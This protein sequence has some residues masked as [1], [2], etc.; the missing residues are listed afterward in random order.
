MSNNLRQMTKSIFSELEFAV[1]QEH[2]DFIVDVERHID[3]D[4]AYR[5]KCCEFLKYAKIIGLNSPFPF[6]IIFIEYKEKVYLGIDSRYAET[7][8]RYGYIVEKDLWL[9]AGAELLCAA[10]KFGRVKADSD[11]IIQY[12]LGIEP[13]EGQDNVVFSDTDIREL[14][15]DI[16]LFNLDINE[17]SLSVQFQQDL[18]RIFLLT[19]RENESVDGNNSLLASLA[20]KANCRKIATNLVDYINI[21][22]NKM[23]F[24]TLYQCMEYLFIPNRAQEFASNY[25]MDLSDAI[26]L[27][28]N[29]PMRRDEK[30]NLACVIKNYASDIAINDFYEKMCSNDEAV[31]KV[32]KVTSCIYDLRCCIAHFR[33]GQSKENL[34]DD[35]NVAFEQMLALLDDIYGNLDADVQK[36]CDGTLEVQL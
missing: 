25:N 23:R 19:Y 20:S 2:K 36:M 18:L 13:D 29:E 24:L 7:M 15:F 27:H 31:N 3:I 4:S 14:F 10:K 5:E 33:Y 35:W 34:V 9:R 11:T 16:T 1:R 22:D 6:S 17:L 28:M 32:E 8:E 26:R 30:T 21:S 12:C